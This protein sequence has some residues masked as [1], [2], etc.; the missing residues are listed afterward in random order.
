[1]GVLATFEN[2]G[3]GKKDGRVG[4]PDSSKFKLRIRFRLRFEFGL[5]LRLALWVSYSVIVKMA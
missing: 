5:E 4:F 1:M 2:D 3:N